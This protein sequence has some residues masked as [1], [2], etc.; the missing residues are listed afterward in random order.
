MA[1]ALL[2]WWPDGPPGTPWLHRPLDVCLAVWGTPIII[3]LAAQMLCVITRTRLKHPTRASS[4]L[5]FYHRGVLVLRVAALVALAGHLL[6]TPWPLMLADIPLIRAIPGLPQLCILVPYFMSLIAIWWML[7][8]VEKASR[9]FTPTAQRTSRWR[10]V[11][12]NLRH[13]VLIVALPLAIIVI[14]FAATREYRPALIRL[15]GSKWAP[16]ALLGVV[17]MAIFVFSPILLRRVWATS[18][19]PEGPLRDKLLAMCGRIGLRVR[20]ILVWHSDG[21]MVNAA[22]MGLFPRVRYIMLSDTLLASMTDDEIEAVFGH[23]AGHVRHHHIPYFLLFA[24]ISMLIASGVIEF[25]ARTCRDANAVWHLSDDAI[26]AL[27]LAAI[28]PIWGIGFGWVSRRFERQADVF[29][30]SCASPP[31]RSD[32]CRLPCCVHD[33]SGAA[34][35]DAVCATGAGIFVKALGKVALLNGIPPTERSWRHSS[36]AS[37]M[38]FLTEL[39]GDP[40]MARRFAGRVRGIKRALVLLSILGLGI[41]AVYLWQNPGY[42]REILTSVIEPLRKL[43]K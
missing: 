39:S 9:G 15:T 19:L 13:Q 14:T 33:G 23:E 31:K 10:Y 16:E 43:W 37:R 17:A 2:L 21:V 29:G 26:Q 27:G 4:A 8:P 6:V 22:V 32:N 12:F 36:I 30:A 5:P 42:R 24:L 1:F 11:V 34:N 18:P 25:L 40:M 3:A 20:E 35:G 41:S 28:V 38:R 7:Y